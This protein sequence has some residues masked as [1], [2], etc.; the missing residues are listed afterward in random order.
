MIKLSFFGILSIFCF[1]GSLTAQQAIPKVTIAKFKNSTEFKMQTT[2]SVTDTFISLLMETKRF[3]VI[4]RERLQ[5]LNDESVISGAVKIAGCDYIFL[6]NIATMDVKTSKSK[7]KIMSISSSTADVSVQVNVRIVEA[8]TGKVVFSLFGEDK[9][10]ESVSTSEIFSK[11]NKDPMSNALINN[12]MKDALK[13]V[14]AKIVVSLFPIK[15]VTVKEDKVYLNVGENL[16][17]KV[18]DEYEIFAVGEAIVDADTGLSL[19]ADETLVGKVKIAEI[20]E[21][22]SIASVDKKIIDKIKAGAIC[23]PAKKKVK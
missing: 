5:D 17:L 10:S 19:G 2:D 4:E 21:K 6:N 22:Y 20:K 15:V 14:V 7:V 9:K 16:G 18:G 3:E 8:K 23:R 13:D 1:L 11:T 12:T